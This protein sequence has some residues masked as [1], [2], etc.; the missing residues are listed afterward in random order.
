MPAGFDLTAG[1]LGKGN[2]LAPYVG[3]KEHGHILDIIR[4]WGGY[5]E[6]SASL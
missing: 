4:N 2:L 3:W 1:L 5:G 6:Y